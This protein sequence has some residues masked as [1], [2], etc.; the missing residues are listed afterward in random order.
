MNAAIQ[1]ASWRSAGDSGTVLADEG[2]GDGDAV[3]G[4]IVFALEALSRHAAALMAT[5]NASASARPAVP[6]RGARELQSWGCVIRRADFNIQA[7]SA[8][9]RRHD[10]EPSAVDPDLVTFASDKLTLQR[11][12]VPPEW[13]RDDARHLSGSWLVSELT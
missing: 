6:S 1:A 3:V 2:E 11:L 10:D 8:E 12:P 4:G 9:P 7:S 13:H 5:M